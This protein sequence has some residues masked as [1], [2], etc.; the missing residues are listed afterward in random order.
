MRAMRRRSGRRRWRRSRR[1][2]PCFFVGKTAGERNKKEINGEKE[3]ITPVSNNAC[4]SYM[5][6]RTYVAGYS[7]F[8]Q[9]WHRI[10]KNGTHHEIVDLTAACVRA[11]ALESKFNFLQKWNDLIYRN[12]NNPIM[13]K[14]KFSR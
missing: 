9:Y 10:K 8:I 4:G 7:E 5:Y 12:V 1:Q 11:C 3:R 6:L 13:S 2:R 14:S